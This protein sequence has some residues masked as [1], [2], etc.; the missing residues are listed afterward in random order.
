MA[1]FA[2]YLVGGVAAVLLMDYAPS[3]TWQLGTLSPSLLAQAPAMQ[4]EQSRKGDRLAP[5]R[6][7]Q[8][9][10]EIATVELVGLR[11]AAIVY[12]DRDGREL[13]RTD[14]MTNVTIVSKGLSLPEVT[15]RQHAGSAVKPVPVNVRDVTREQPQLR[16]R[17]TP[18]P[19]RVPLGC[20]P[21]FSPV[22]QPSMAHV[23]GRCMA[24]TH[25]PTKL[26]MR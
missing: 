19:R 26:A 13:F 17:K 7:L 12:R 23:T 15:V 18:A 24:E 1:H 11:D 4:A 20:E 14:P 16:D 5:A 3:A 21:S 8:S 22:A 6:A 9:R 2:P 25:A 10:P